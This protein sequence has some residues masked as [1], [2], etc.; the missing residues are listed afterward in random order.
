MQFATVISTH[1]RPTRRVAN[2]I[3]ELTGRCAS[4]RGAVLG[5]AVGTGL[6]ALMVFTVRIIKF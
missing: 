1:E 3:H 5:M 4:A 2:D 6:W